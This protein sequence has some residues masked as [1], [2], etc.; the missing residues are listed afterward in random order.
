MRWPAFLVAVTFAMSAQAQMSPAASKLT[1]EAIAGDAP[2]SGPSLEKPAISPDG[3]RVTFLRGKS[4]NKNRLDLWAY[5]VA[6]GKT[7]MLVD[8]NVVLPG[9]EVLSDAE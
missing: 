2:L 6:S 1:L 7:Q 9:E 3:S 5:D 8:S 4:D